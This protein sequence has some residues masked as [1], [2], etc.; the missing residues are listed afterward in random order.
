VFALAALGSHANAITSELFISEYLEGSYFNKALEIYNGTG[1]EIDLATAGYNVQIFYGGITS[2]G[3]T[4][5]LTGTVS[6]NDV[7]V[8]AP[9]TA[10]VNIL[11]KTNQFTGVGVFW[12]T[13]NDTVVLRKGSTMIDV[14][15]QI[16]VDPGTGWGTSPTSTANATLQRKSSI[17]GGDTNSADAFD[18]SIE[19]NGFTQD[20]F[21]GL[22]THSVA[23]PVPI[24]STLLLLGSG[25]VGMVGIGRK[26]FKK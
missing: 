4:I 5:N 7:Y 11:L 26:R 17:W 23:A 10:D 19:W 24:P 13:G 12:F 21:G 15:G 22:G 14:I 2:A 18:P 20:T 25:L 6:N 8:L 9:S 1:S 16:G 3:T